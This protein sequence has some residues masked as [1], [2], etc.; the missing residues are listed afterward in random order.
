ML[1]EEITEFKL[2]RPGPPSCT[3]TSKTFFYDRIKISQGKYSSDYL[4][5]KTLQEATYPASSTWAKSLTKFNLKMRDFK[6]VLDL[7]SK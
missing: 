2:R 1:F 7:I 4:L 3:R 6:R 5:L